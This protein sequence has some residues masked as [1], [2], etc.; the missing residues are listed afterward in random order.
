VDKHS[1]FKT[2]G[3]TVQTLRLASIWN[4][5]PFEMT[6]G[7]LIM[8]GLLTRPAAFIASGEMAVAYFKVH[9]LWSFFPIVNHGELP[10]LF[11]F[12][13]LYFA[14][15]GAGEWS[16]DRLLFASKRRFDQRFISV[17]SA[18]PRSAS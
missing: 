12:I 18:Q 9:I 2:L 6:A 7:T 3:E 1:Q 13:F 11:C 16:L 15:V 10:V 8:I 14:V 17:R 4:V 5:P